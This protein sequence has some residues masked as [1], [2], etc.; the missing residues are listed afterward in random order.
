M[1]VELIRHQ[2]FG[3]YPGKIFCLP[4]TIRF[5]NTIFSCNVKLWLERKVIMLMLSANY[6]PVQCHLDFLNNY[7]FNYYQ[8]DLFSPLIS[9]TIS[10]LN[11]FL[12]GFL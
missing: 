12:H 3:C 1:F 10:Y 2:K 4:I 7:K 11:D 8:E 5:H 9:Y 6:E